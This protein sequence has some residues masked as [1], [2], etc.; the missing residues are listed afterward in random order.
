MI[1]T[2]CFLSVRPEFIEK[3]P[4]L[5]IRDRGTNVRLC[6]KARGYPRPVVEWKLNDDLSAM[7]PK[8]Q[9]DGC[10][11][12]DMDKESTQGTE[13]VCLAENSFGSANISALVYARSFGNTL[14]VLL[15]L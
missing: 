7:M 12:V 1:V 6:C 2:F 4:E 14:S 5:I 13:Y 9:E 8:S 3:P 10:L 11:E 15:L